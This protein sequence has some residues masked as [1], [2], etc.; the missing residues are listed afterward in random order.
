MKQKEHHAVNS[1]L[2]YGNMR[3]GGRWQVLYDLSDESDAPWNG[4]NSL[5]DLAHKPI[6]TV[7]GSELRKRDSMSGPPYQPLHFSFDSQDDAQG[8]DVSMSQG[9]LLE[10]FLSLARKEREETRRR[11]GG[12]SKPRNRQLQLTVTA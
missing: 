1:G 2:E 9:D 5:Y 4:V 11:V 3:P 10:V 8:R 7:H 12:K 6:P